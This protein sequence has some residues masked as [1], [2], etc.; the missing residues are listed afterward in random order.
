MSYMTIDIRDPAQSIYYLILC[1]V[2]CVSQLMSDK[3]QYKAR[4]D[5]YFTFWSQLLEIPVIPSASAFPVNESK[6]KLI[7][8]L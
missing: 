8:L 6:E 7:P 4:I 5:Q 1:F 3:D 2:N